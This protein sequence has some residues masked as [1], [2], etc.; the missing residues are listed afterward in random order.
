MFLVFFDITFLS[1]SKI[2]R[3]LAQK[4]QIWSNMI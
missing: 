3:E 2:E 1:L 4:D